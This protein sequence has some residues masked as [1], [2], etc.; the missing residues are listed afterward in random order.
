MFKGSLFSL[1]VAV[2][3]VFTTAG[4][5]A[6]VPQLISYQGRLVDSL[7]NAIDTTT[8]LT[9]SIWENQASFV[10]LWSETHPDVVIENGLFSVT[11]GQYTDFPGTLFDGSIRYL[12]I[13]VG[14]S[15]MMDPLMPI[16]SSAYSLRSAYADTATY[17]MAGAGGGGGWV[18]DGSV[19]HLE[20]NG[21]RVGIGTTSPGENLVVGGDLGSFP[22]ANYVVCGNSNFEEYSGFKLG[23]NGDNHATINWYGDGDQLTFNTRSLGTSYNNTLVLREGN[24][25]IGTDYPTE[26]LVI[27]HNLATHASGDMLTVGNNDPG[28]FSGLALGKDADNRFYMA[29]DNDNDYV[30]MGSR[31]GGVF[32]SNNLV[33]R[34]GN[35]GIGTSDPQG[36]LHVV[37]TGNSSVQLPDNAIYDVEILDEPGIG[38]NSKTT[39]YENSYG[40]WFT[41][42]ERTCNFPTTGYA[43]VIATC[44]YR[45]YLRELSV[46]FGITCNSSIA[47]HSYKRE[48][49]TTEL[50]AYGMTETFTVHEVFEV[51]SG[52]NVVSFL[53]KNDGNSR[54]W[55]S[56]AGITIMFFPTAYGTVSRL[57]ENSPDTIDFSGMAYQDMENREEPPENNTY[58][59]LEARLQAVEVELA[60]LKQDR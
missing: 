8:D 6:G 16:V 56:D 54:G 42:L 24:V 59:A 50:G 41:V 25:G 18:D 12:G 29:Y 32:Y 19:V 4:A 23:Y 52:S 36:K 48:F 3:L 57:S 2:V 49:L 15:P 44:E 38:A 58:T 22:E 11:L 40:S 9:F 27:G 55:I 5:A 26:P 20:S 10:P 51:S 37:G 14:G 39:E 7:G 60:R 28:G 30:Y 34:T 1:V 21:D 35:V 31:I 46:S 43:V 13:E 47:P 45:G 17:A 53:F 33:L